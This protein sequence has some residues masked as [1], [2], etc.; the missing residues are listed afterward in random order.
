[1][2]PNSVDEFDALVIQVRFF[3]KNKETLEMIPK[4]RQAFQR[5]VFHTHEAPRQFKVQNM[6]FY[7]GK[8]NFN[9]KNVPS[10]LIFMQKVCS[11]YNK[12]IQ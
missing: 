11:E 4:K 12:I 2:G 1:M 6:C 7:L 3:L 8:N 10:F 9:P 5:Y